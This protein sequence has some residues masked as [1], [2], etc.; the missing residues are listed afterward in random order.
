MKIQTTRFGELEVADE[1]VIEFV[2]ALP[3]CP[4]KRYALLERELPP[5]VRWLQSM[6]KPEIALVLV[7]P[8]ALLPDYDGRPKPDEIRDL[9]P[10][11][12]S[13]K[14]WVIAS[15]GETS[16]SLILNLFAPIFVNPEQRLA[17]QIPLVGSSY[18]T[19]APWPPA[20]GS[21]E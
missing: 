19:R 6:D 20:G 15:S 4:G 14:R 12:S 5:H 8:N 9:C 7:D 3:G 18:S 17:L 10:N 11:P 13:A 2:E 1:D 16:D 21:S